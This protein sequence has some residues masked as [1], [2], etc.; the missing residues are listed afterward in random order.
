VQSTRDGIFA[1]FGAP[2]AEEDHPQRAIYAAVRM[3][4][5]RNAQWSLDRLWN[6]ILW[7]TMG[8][9]YAPLR[10][11]KWLVG[12]LSLGWVFFKCGYKHNW[13]VATEP[14]PK[15]KLFEP[16]SP[17]IYSLETLLP[18]VDLN[19][20]KH[21]IPDGN[22][23]GGRWLRRYLGCMLLRVCSLLQS[24]SWVLL[25]A[26]RFDSSEDSQAGARP[27]RMS[28]ERPDSYQATILRRPR[29]PS[30]G[31]GASRVETVTH[32]AGTLRSS[33]PFAASRRATD[34]LL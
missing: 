7:L 24:S 10:A 11:L 22:T 5:D 18:L 30:S 17:F 21:Y 19:Q 26:R 23:P 32:M 27:V 9:G 25:S 29:V 34:A 2:V 20:A 33:L 31:Q 6:W 28:S 14:D 12:L 15:L 13:I 4:E 8:Y 16:F 3:Q 1:L